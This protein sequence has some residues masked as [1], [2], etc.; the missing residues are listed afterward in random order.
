[1]AGT[2]P[3]IFNYDSQSRTYLAVEMQRKLVVGCQK[4]FEHPPS[5]GRKILQEAHFLM[6]PC[7]GSHVYQKLLVR[8]THF[9][10]HSVILYMHT[11][12]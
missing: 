8:L 6:V 12:S 4:D 11:S 7:V 1:M 5:K 10:I 3:V 2:R 9:P